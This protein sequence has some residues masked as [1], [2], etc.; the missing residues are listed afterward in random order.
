MADDTISERV[1][2]VD[3]DLEDDSLGAAAAV[4]RVSC[5]CG[6]LSRSMIGYGVNSEEAYRNAEAE[7]AEFCSEFGGIQKLTRL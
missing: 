2:S 7:A 1:A 6:K 5:M 3:V 4:V